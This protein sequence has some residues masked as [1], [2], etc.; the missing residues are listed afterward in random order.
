LIEHAYTDT[1]KFV[2]LAPEAHIVDV[3]QVIA[4]IYWVVDHRNDRGVNIRVLNLSFGTD[5]LQ[6]RSV[7]PLARAV[8][9]AW[10]QG[11]VVVVAPATKARPP[12]PLPCQRHLPW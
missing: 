7:D 10:N 9:Y 5:S 1:T 8:E 2:G 4:A 6:S 3:S 11:I 12:S